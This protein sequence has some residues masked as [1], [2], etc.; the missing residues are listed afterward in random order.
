MLAT[1]T[2]AITSYAEICSLRATKHYTAFCTG[3]VLSLGVQLGETGLREG[4]MDI[5][6]TLSIICGFFLGATFMQWRRSTSTNN[7]CIFGA[8]A[9]LLV[10]SHL[11]FLS[12]DHGERE[13]KWYLLLY[14]P[15]F[16]AMDVETAQKPLGVLTSMI[17]GHLLHLAKVSATKI[18]GKKQSRDEKRKALY[19]NHVLAGLIIGSVFAIVVNRRLSAMGTPNLWYH[20]MLPVGPLLW[21]MIVLHMNQCGCEELTCK[22]IQ[23]QEPPSIAEK[24]EEGRHGDEDENDETE[25]EDDGFEPVGALQTYVVDSSLSHMPSVQPKSAS[26]PAE[27]HVPPEQPIV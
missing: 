14:P 23:P 13:M 20:S 24:V 17:T 8:Y 5:L 7:A 11:V 3:N 10:F 27:Q 1:C 2:A 26:A 6:F 12:M 15:L 21:L 18:A 9:I 16:A 19:G 25:S 4:I 22:T